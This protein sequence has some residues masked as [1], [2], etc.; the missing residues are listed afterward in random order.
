MANPSEL[1]NKVKQFSYNAMRYVGL[2]IMP[3]VVVFFVITALSFLFTKGL[4]PTA[5]SDR[6]F[7]VGMLIMALGGVV[8]FA[9]MISSS[10]KIFLTMIAIQA[11]SKRFS[12]QIQKTVL[13]SK[14][15]TMLAAKSGW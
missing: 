14:T 2:R 9:Q 13:K 10:G 1:V 12:I 6:F 3:A 5:F 7:L 4:T 15:V 8:I 11:I